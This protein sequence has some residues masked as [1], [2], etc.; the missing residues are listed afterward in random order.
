MKTHRIT[1]VATFA[2]A[3]L[4]VLSLT[5]LFGACVRN[6]RSEPGAELIGY[7][8]QTDQMSMLANEGSPVV[9]LAHSHVQ[10]AARAYF[11]VFGHWPR[12]WKDIER[13]GLCQVELVTPAGAQIDPDD[14][15]LNFLD[16]VTYEFEDR[17]PAPIVN[18]CSRFEE[19]IIDHLEVQTPRTYVSVLDDFEPGWP[20]Y[21]QVQE[22]KADPARLKQWAILSQVRTGLRQYKVL[23]GHYPKD[24]QAF[25]DSGVGVIDSR[26]INT[27]TNDTYRGDG[28]PNDF[29]YEYID[30]PGISPT[31]RPIQADGSVCQIHFNY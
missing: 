2:I 10:T 6:I 14:G 19:T 30:V 20:G 5:C 8:N 27:L 13:E 31:L 18:W 22:C 4:G 25:L 9:L 29:L 15:K 3:V 11:K 28:S 21:D 26:S 1:A 16:D 17:N 23:Y 24:F 7:Q 12:T